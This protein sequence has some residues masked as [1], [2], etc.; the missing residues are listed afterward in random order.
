MVPSHATYRATSGRHAA[1]RFSKSGAKN[2]E[3][4]YSR[5]YKWN[6]SAEKKRKAIEDAGPE[7]AAV[8]GGI[9]V[10]LIAP[11]RPVNASRDGAANPVAPSAAGFDC[12]RLRP[13]ADFGL[14]P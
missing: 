8:D 4:A 3:D 6:Q 13:A 7:P 9:A 14:H 1:L 11:C 5:H 2:I 10:G 12:S